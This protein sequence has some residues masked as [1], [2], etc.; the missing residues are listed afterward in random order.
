MARSE[1]CSLMKTTT[2]AMWLA[3][4]LAGSAGAEELLPKSAI[5]EPLQTE[6]RE[7]H[8][9]LKQ[10][11]ESGGKTAAAADELRQALRP[12][13]Q[14]EEELALPPLGF[15]RE[16]VKGEVSEELREKIIATSKRL[17]AELPRMLEE[18]ETIVAKLKT[19]QAAAAE[20]DKE[21]VGAFA[22]ELILHAR[23]EEEVLYPAA[24]LVG[25]YLSFKK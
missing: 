1:R 6:H 12:H 19:L 18:H 4:A 8:E 21:E 14:R 17:K 22:E 24:I 23:M 15:L 10:A 16:A 9:R 3:L 20:E 25:E 5:P 7:L 13:F 2:F 11:L